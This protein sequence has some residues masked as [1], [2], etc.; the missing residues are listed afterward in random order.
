MVNINHC[1]WSAQICTVGCD[2]NTSSAGIAKQHNNYHTQATSTCT[3]TFGNFRI[4]REARLLNLYPC[5]DTQADVITMNVAIHV[6]FTPVQQ[7]LLP[8]A[9]NSWD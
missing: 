4:H 2:H 8:M 3:R 5:C 7:T 9:I 1:L 6:Y